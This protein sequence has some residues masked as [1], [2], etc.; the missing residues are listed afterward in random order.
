MQVR[1]LIDQ[2]M[3]RANP[4]TGPRP[5]YRQHPTKNFHRFLDG[6][7]NVFPRTGEGLSKMPHNGRKR[8]VA[9]SERTDGRYR[10]SIERGLAR[11][12]QDFEAQLAADDAAR[13]ARPIPYRLDDAAQLSAPDLQP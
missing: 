3:M 2:F 11:E 9:S 1:K 6:A 4:K 7:R 12:A 13:A 8:R 10:R 5:I